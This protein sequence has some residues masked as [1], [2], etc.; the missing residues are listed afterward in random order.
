MSET[1]GGVSVRGGSWKEIVTAA[2]RSLLDTKAR[3]RQDT[4][5]SQLPAMGL[6]NQSPRAESKVPVRVQVQESEKKAMLGIETGSRV[7]AGF[8]GPCCAL[9]LGRRLP[10]R[11]G[12]QASCIAGWFTDK[13]RSPHGL[14]RVSRVRRL[15]SSLQ[16]VA[17]KLVRQRGRVGVLSIFCW[18]LSVSSPSVPTSS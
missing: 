15:L 16:K 17:L 9:C 5:E 13:P 8:G 1:R 11:K 2:P 6:R 12:S 3:L 14:G 18:P 7:Q 4:A 10:P